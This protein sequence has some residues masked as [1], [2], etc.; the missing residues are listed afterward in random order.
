MSKNLYMH[1]INGK[2]AMYQD[3]TYICYIDSYTRVSYSETFVDSLKAI[4]RQ[5]K[6]SLQWHEQNGN[7]DYKDRNYGYIRIKDDRDA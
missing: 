3:G 7:T 4:K 1:T 5:Q 2:P 6:W